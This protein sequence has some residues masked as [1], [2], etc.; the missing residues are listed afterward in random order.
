MNSPQTSSYFSFDNS[1]PPH[2]STSPRERNL[3]RRPSLSCRS[4]SNS[5]LCGSISAVLNNMS[6]S[7][8]TLSAEEPLIEKFINLKEIL[9]LKDEV[10][11]INLLCMGF[12]Y[13]LQIF[14]KIKG[15]IG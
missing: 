13:L 9:A 6:K 1:S 7:D 2:L 5:S 14:G 8:N 12:Q 11:I 10:K 4:S 15:V 3:S